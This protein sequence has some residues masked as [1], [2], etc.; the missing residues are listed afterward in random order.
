MDCEPVVPS[1]IRGQF[2]GIFEVDSGV[3]SSL[4]MLMKIVA[5]CSGFKLLLWSE[6]LRGKGW[7]LAQ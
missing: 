5:Q 7:S 1:F 6:C 3:E 4:G 2:D